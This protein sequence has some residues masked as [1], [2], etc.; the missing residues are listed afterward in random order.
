MAGTS[1][2]W[3]SLRAFA[4]PG[5]SGPGN[6][7]EAAGP[8]PFEVRVP[9][10][11]GDVPGRRTSQGDLAIH[12]GE[13]VRVKA[14]VPEDIKDT[15]WRLRLIGEVDVDRQLHT[16]TNFIYQY[17]LIDDALDPHTTHHR[18]YSLA[19]RSGGEEVPRRAYFR[20]FGNGKPEEYQFRVW[21]KKLGVEALP[22]G[23]VGV[24]VAVYLKRP[25]RNA[26]NMTGTPDHVYFLDGGNGTQD[27]Q[28]RL[29]PIHLA[30]DEASLLFTV[31]GEKFR[32][33]VWFEDPQFMGPDGLSS[34]PAF[35]PT[36]PYVPHRYWIGENLC[37]VEWPRFRLTLNGQEFFHDKLYQPEHAWPAAELD[38][39][40]DLVRPGNNELTL[41]LV[42]DHHGALAYNLRKLEWLRLPN[43]R[44]EVVACPQLV[45]SSKDFGILVKTR[46]PNEEMAV[47][48]EP[49]AGRQQAGIAPVERNL[50]FPQAGLHC[51]NFRAGQGGPGGAI[52]FRIGQ[53]ERQASV[54]RVVE[55][56]EDGVLVGSGDILYSSTDRP[57]MRRFHAWYLHH[58]LGNCIVYRHIYHF[59]GTQV[60]D[61][62]AWK[63]ALAL[64][65]AA[66][67]KYSF[68]VCGSEMPGTAAI[69]TEDMLAGPSFRGAQL[70]EHD[71]L[72][73]YWGSATRD[74]EEE[75][76]LAVYER[77]PARTRCGRIG[78]PQLWGGRAGAPLYFDSHRAHNMQEG[79][80]Y[81]CEN[82][83]RG[84]T[85]ATRHSGPSM[86]FKYFFQA[87]YKWLAA[88]TLYGPHEIVL[89]ALRGASLAYGQPRYGAHIAASWATSPHND[90]A[91]FRRYFLGLA[92]T[93]I[94]G[95][96]Y[97]YIEDGL[98]HMEQGHQ[99][100]D[101]FSVACQG[102]LK[103]HQEFYHFTRAHSRRGKMRVPVGF[104]HGQYD[105]W[106]CWTRSH[107]WGQEGEEWDFADPEKSWDLLRVFFPRSVLAPIYKTP[108]PHEPMG[109]FSG[110][111]Y[112]PADI[113]P[114]EAQISTLANYSALIF[115]GWNTADADQIERLRQYVEVGGHLILALPHLS[116]EVRRNQPPQP[117]AGPRVHQLLGLEIRG[118]KQSSGKWTAQNVADN[119]W[120]A[121]HQG[122]NVQLGDVALEGA[123]ARITDEAGT[124]V[125]LENKVGKGQVTFVNVAAY[126]GDA[127]VEDLYR[128]L[129][130]AAGKRAVA[131]QKSNVWVKGS[132][133]VSFAVYDWDRTPGQPP[134]ST[135]Y[136]L[137]VNW[138]SDNPPVSE[139]HLLWKDA[140]VPLAITR[141]KIHVVTVAGDWGVWTQDINTDVT[142]IQP[143]SRGV[144]ISL[145][146]QGK[147]K[148]QVLYRPAA[149]GG[150]QGKLR[151]ESSHGPLVFS[152]AADAPGPWQTEIT[153]NGP[154]RIRLVPHR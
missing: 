152:R 145:Q 103:V 96:E 147:T 140:E 104:L 72:Y 78:D 125:I 38:V 91:A 150:A 144:E 84:L 153:L 52:R 154:E 19:L 101:R 87:G 120:V 49:V 74:P 151:G 27:W 8:A 7:I 35:G 127:A 54:E 102:H 121:V 92:T 22:G 66:G 28:E 88:E 93:Y 17:R 67:L 47:S 142:G 36:R 131:E 116:T 95:T 11:L 43:G 46:E 79:A 111:P 68:I 45:D 75:L 109:F 113:V 65:E 33:R 134:I 18:T 3:D 83:R 100:D 123:T 141:G 106:T 86:L 60:L 128:G 114:T 115:L 9:I 56:P 118:L 122:G 138:W 21:I 98:W 94:H 55:R 129:L 32:G 39:P 40:A 76:F 57:N 135:V 20:V 25:G 37:Q 124:P 143:D 70:H 31:T 107:V 108:C 26:G 5:T 136:L 16:E 24:E 105:G 130:H 51:V 132:E 15:A 34:L 13:S 14:L 42:S 2:T 58:S 29:L 59:G 149:S 81:F 63:E 69:P 64:C 1:L 48:V 90:P 110:T 71:G 61:P 44:L 10:S 53:E 4:G 146:G 112:G 97:M 137:N 12:P 148:L 30:G 126:P 50:V 73:Y 117:L 41:Q 62:E 77:F 139:A 23:R 133:D 99:A 82:I 85:L 89:G 119:D 6:I 80:E